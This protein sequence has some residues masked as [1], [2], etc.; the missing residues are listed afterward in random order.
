MSN[1]SVLLVQANEG[2]MLPIVDLIRRST[3]AYLLSAGFPMK[4]V[5]ARCLDA[6]E[7]TIDKHPSSISSISPAQA[8]P[9]CSDLDI[10]MSTPD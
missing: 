10:F 1:S 3:A 2:F 9:H 8:S 6:S 4:L 7:V 5:G